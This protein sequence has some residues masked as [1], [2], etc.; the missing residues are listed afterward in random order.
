MKGHGSR[1]PRKSKY[2]ATYS[3]PNTVW[4]QPEGGVSRPSKYGTS[5]AT[6]EVRSQMVKI[7]P[8]LRQFARSLMGDADSS[9]DLV[10]ETYARALAHLDQW[11]PGMRLDSWMVRIAQNLWTDNRRT[12]RSHGEIVDIEVIGDLLSLDGLVIA[13]NRIVLEKLTKEIAQLTLDQRNVISLVC[14]FG[15]SYKETGK[16]LNLP[17][18]TVMS[19]L[20]RARYAL[21]KIPAGGRGNDLA[22]LL[23]AT[24]RRRS[25][26]DYICHQAL[27]LR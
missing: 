3:R 7:L 10:Q 19:R 15:M 13:E 4:R 22:Y 25:R 14:G 11:Q 9:E 17:E 12:E 24:G 21:Q 6:E 23:Q 16:M 1:K 26:I 5:A 8:R 18:G 27:P 2:N 20:A